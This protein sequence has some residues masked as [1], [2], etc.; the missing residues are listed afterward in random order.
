M[1]R[2]CGSSSWRSSRPSR[3]ARSSRWPASP[4]DVVGLPQGRTTGPTIYV[5]S[6]GPWQFHG[7]F[8]LAAEKVVG[9]GRPVAIRVVDPAQHPKIAPYVSPGTFFRI[10]A[11]P[12][13]TQTKIWHFTTA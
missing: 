3:R 6:A 8:H 2:T 12:N 11:G 1:I 9:P 13:D 5:F 10:V 7:K 4:G